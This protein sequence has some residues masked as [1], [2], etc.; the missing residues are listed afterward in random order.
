MDK[1]EFLN[2]LAEILMIDTNDLKEEA[3]LNSFDDFDS[4]AILEIS[5]LFEKNLGI[6]VF[7]IEIK[8]MKQIKDLLKL[9]KFI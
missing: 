1:N 4:V 6:E 5:I 7:P 8:K 2:A 3:E 9:G